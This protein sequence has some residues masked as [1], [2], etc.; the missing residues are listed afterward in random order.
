MSQGYTWSK[1]IENG[2]VG[3]NSSLCA[4][5]NESWHQ[6]VQLAGRDFPL[7]QSLILESE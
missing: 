3:S 4:P 1:A 2:V 5:D 7:S 6:T